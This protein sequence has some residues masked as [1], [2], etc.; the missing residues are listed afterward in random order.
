VER[1][2]NRGQH[3][4]IQGRQNLLQSARACTGVNGDHNVLFFLCRDVV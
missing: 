2:A 4:A 1:F 3:A